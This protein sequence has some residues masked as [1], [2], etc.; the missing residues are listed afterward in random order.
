MFV[1]QSL[2]NHIDYKVSMSLNHLA[3][4]CYILV[5]ITGENIFGR[6]VAI[7]SRIEIENEKKNGR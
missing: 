7:L 1:T 3:V 5:T 2:P 4:I 6:I